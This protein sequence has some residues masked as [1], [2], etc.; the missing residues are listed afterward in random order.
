ME[1]HFGMFR[2]L[3]LISLDAAKLVVW[4]LKQMIKS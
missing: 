3:L 4:L 1:K 2:D